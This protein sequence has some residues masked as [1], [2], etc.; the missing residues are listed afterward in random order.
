MKLVANLLLILV[1]IISLSISII[2]AYFCKD[3]ELFEL[4]LLFLVS[5]IA[6]LNYKKIILDKA[7]INIIFLLVMVNVIFLFIE[8]KGLIFFK[9]TIILILAILLSKTILPYMSYKKYLKRIHL[10][11]WFILFGLV[12]EYGILAFIGEQELS[13]LFMC[14][15][16]ITGVRGYTSQFNMTKYILPYHIT[17]LNSI[18]LGSQAAS[19]LAIIAYIWFIY[20]YKSSGKKVEQFAAYL[21]VV[22]LFL[23]PSLTALLII[24]IVILIMYLVHLKSNLKEQ[25]KGFFRLYIGLIMSFLL[26]FALITML[27]AK[28]NSI[29]YIYETYVLEQ[30]NGFAYFS[31]REILFGLTYERELELFGLGEI[32]F[33]AH[34]VKYGF[35]GSVI[36]YGSI[37]HYI[38]RSTKTSFVT[39]L[40]PNIFILFV[41]I[42]GNIHY[43]VMLYNGVM[44]LFILHLAFIIHIGSSQ[45]VA[46][47]KI[48]I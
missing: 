34:L 29:N 13:N 42:L 44:E 26:I 36:F 28:Y 15:G 7:D 37:L 2:E 20:S 38:L 41:F 35:L 18:M 1:V 3:L 10:I 40:Y 11:Y 21:S 43:P 47:S 12:I 8:Q 5:A 23:S 46:I 39:Q 22:M 45:R 17:G 30:I 6:F 25:I 33:L 19:Q 16:E 14:N 27:E 24:S 48:D 32:A 4:G 31:F 9:P